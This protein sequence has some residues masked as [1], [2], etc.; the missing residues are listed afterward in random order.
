LVFLGLVCIVVYAF[1]INEN[2]NDF[3]TINEEPE[4]FL[5]SKKPEYT[6]FINEESNNL[7][8]NEEAINSFNSEFGTGVLRVLFIDD[9]CKTQC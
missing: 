6:Y 8:I 7:V 9:N 2:L 3:V 1:I 4:D 5:I